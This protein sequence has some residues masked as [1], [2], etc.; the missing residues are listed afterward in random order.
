MH[1]D[2]RQTLRRHWPEYLMEAAGLGFF[3]L[4]ACAFT[5]L[6]Y[7]PESPVGRS[8][9]SDIL[10]RLLMG[11]AMGSTAVALIYSPWGR[12]SGAHLNP[13]VTLTFW[14]L[15]RTWCRCPIGRSGSARGS[16]R[17]IRTDT[18]CA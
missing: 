9:E 14:R 16:W 5:V 18:R 6:F 7:Y 10:R 4:S 1:T 2:M 17:A 12:R 11:M 8:V 15:I 13:V 3:M